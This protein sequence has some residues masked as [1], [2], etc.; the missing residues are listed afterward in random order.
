MR[1]YRLILEN[2][3]ILATINVIGNHILTSAMLKN[4][5]EAMIKITPTATVKIPNCLGM[6][7]LK[8][9]GVRTIR[10]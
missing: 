2:A 7:H 4:A 5:K 3:S 1:R 6:N 9:K 8:R 10:P